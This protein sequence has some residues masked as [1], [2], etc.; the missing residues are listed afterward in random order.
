MD[1]K[2]ARVIGILLV[3]PA[4]AFLIGGES[5]M[6]YSLIAIGALLIALSTI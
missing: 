1:N 5:T 3:V 2:I 6:C 4:T